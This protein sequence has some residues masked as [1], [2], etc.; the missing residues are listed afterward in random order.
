MTP[1][2]KR[3]GQPISIT[4]TDDQR[5]WVDSLVPP[6]GSRA[7]VVRDLIAAAM[8]SDRAKAKKG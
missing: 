5:A 2:R 7:R 8:R 3:V 4:L 1:G 6:G